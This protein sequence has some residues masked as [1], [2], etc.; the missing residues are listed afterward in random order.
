MAFVNVRVVEGVLDKDERQRLI[1]G[2]TDLVVEIEGKNNPDFK[3]YCW[4]IVDEID[5]G[6]LG[7]AGEGLST[8]AV[9]QEQG[10]S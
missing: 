6:M 8:E 9:R 5:S 7:V 3:Q 4:M 2:I 1:D 10:S